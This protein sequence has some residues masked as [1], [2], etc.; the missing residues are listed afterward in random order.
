MSRRKA[1]SRRSEARVA[2]LSTSQR[3]L[4]AALEEGDTCP[5]CEDG[6]LEVAAGPN[7][8]CHR[9]APCSGCVEDG[10]LCDACG[11][12]KSEGA[13]DE[14]Y[15]ERRLLAGLKAE[16]APERVADSNLFAELLEVQP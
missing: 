15:T 3:N 9:C 8:S 10:L 2:R 7:C 12:R 14:W 1:R 5:Q 16:V 4:L 6:E 11:W 13:P